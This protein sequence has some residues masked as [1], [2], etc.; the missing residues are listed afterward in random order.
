MAILGALLVTDDAGRPVEVGGA[1]LRALLARLAL[2]PGRAVGVDALVADLWGDAPPADQPNALQSLVSRLRRVAAGRAG[3]VRPGRLPA[4]RRPAAGRRDRVRAAGRRRPP[5]AAR[6]SRRPPAGCSTEALAL[7]RGPALAD[8]AGQPWADAAADR[9]TELRL[10]ATEDRI[11]AELA[12]GGHAGVLSGAAGAGP[13]RTRCGSGCAASSCAPSTRPAG[14][15]RR[16]RRTR[17]SGGGWPTSSASTRRPALQEIHLRVLRGDPGAAA[18]RSARTNLPAQLTSFVGRDDDGRGRRAA[19]AAP[20]GHA[21]RAGR[22]RQD[23][24]GRE[25]AV[26]VLDRVPRRRLAGRAGPG[27]RRPAGAAGGAGRARAARD[28]RLGEPTGPARPGRRDRAGSSTRWPT[29]RALL[30]LDNCEHLIDAAARRRRSCSPAARSCASWPPAGSRWASSARRSPPV[31][32]LGP[33]AGRR[34]PGR[35]AGVP[36]GA[37]AGRPGRRGPARLRGRR[38]AT[39]APVVEICRRLDGLPLAI[40]LAAAR[41]RSLPVTEVAA[42]LDDRF[43]LLTGGSRTALPRHRTLRAVVAWSWDLLT[44]AG[45]G[46]GR[47]ARGVP[48]RRHRRR[49]PQAVCAGGPV[50]G[51]D[52][53][54][55]LPRW[56]TSRC[57][58]QLRRRRRRATGCWR[59]SA[60]S[61]SS[62]SPRRARSPRSG[63]GT[64]GTSCALAETADP[65]LRGPT[66]WRGSPGCAPSGTTCSP[67]CACAS[68]PATPTPPTAPRRRAGLVL[69]AARQARRGATCCSAARR[70]PGDGAGRGPGGRAGGRR[71]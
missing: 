71:S 34:D 62:G 5:G 31:A 35:G 40:E 63:T 49:P 36:G 4:R 44:D 52:V 22:R 26:R 9:L 1:R 7:W 14:R 29:R 16:S 50:D 41:L 39:S 27:H 15:P 17:R 24:A 38:R 10:A 19:R 45:G 3:R 69:D 20:A 68:T 25:T 67:R 60:S 6:T 70:V 54:D 57:C 55:L 11:D 61:A 33:A 32:P 2:E 8:V 53:P 30:V 37:A 65:H 51:A 58:R 23:P 47:P 66:S 18:R 21:G 28:A 46:A 12:L 64:R 59:R 48:R 56:S 42:R 43:R 13:R